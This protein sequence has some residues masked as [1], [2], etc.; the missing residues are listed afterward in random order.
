MSWAG[1]G[2]D[3][4]GEWEMWELVVT[5]SCW[6]LRTE[7]VSEASTFVAPASSVPWR[8]PARGTACE[9]VTGVF[10]ESK[11]L[12][13]M[14]NINF[15]YIG[16]SLSSEI[17]QLSSINANTDIQTYSLIH[18]QSNPP[19]LYPYITD[20]Y[21]LQS[22]ECFEFISTALAASSKT[23]QVSFINANNA[24]N[25]AHNLTRRQTSTSQ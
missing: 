4:G 7:I 14:A 25:Q 3:G 21:H 17:A 18:L 6:K 11:R 5:E 2:D 9:H 10:C 22:S 8:T 16:M 12:V 19:N 24:R 13:R 15:T 1:R 20:S 23:A